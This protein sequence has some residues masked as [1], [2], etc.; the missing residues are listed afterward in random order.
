[1]KIDMT[2]KRALVTG[3]G[4]NLNRVRPAH[5]AGNGGRLIRL[6]YRGDQTT[7]QCPA[8]AFEAKRKPGQ[9]HGLVTR[10][11]PRPSETE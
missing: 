8:F 1:M 7:A 4:L 9:C 6:R 2:G 5:R 11:I 3:S 10:R